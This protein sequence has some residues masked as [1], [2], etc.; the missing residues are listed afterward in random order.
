MDIL[1]KQELAGM[2]L[3]YRRECGRDSVVNSLTTIYSDNADSNRPNSTSSIHYDHLL[4]LESGPTIVK[5]RT[6]WRPK[7]V[8]NQGTAGSF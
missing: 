8:S 3:E 1:E 6:M 4:S 2:A 7:R 5:A